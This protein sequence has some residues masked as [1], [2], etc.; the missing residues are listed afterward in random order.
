MY[1]LHC[2]AS[3][4]LGRSCG[5]SGLAWPIQCRSVP[6]NGILQYYPRQGPAQA[7]LCNHE[8]QVGSNSLP[9][10]ANNFALKP[11]KPN[12]RQEKPSISAA[13][14]LF[15]DHTHKH[16]LTH[17]HTQT[18]QQGCVVFTFIHFLKSYDNNNEMTN[19][20]A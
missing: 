16:A 12:P 18:C 10:T 1:F 15:M 11:L 2:S 7:D 3:S 8:Q 6:V 17:K 9:S 20:S 14:F 5:M 4:L 19:P 13:Y